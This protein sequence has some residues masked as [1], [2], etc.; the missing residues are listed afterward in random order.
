MLNLKKDP[1]IFSLL[2]SWIVGGYFRS[3][4]TLALAKVNNIDI[5]IHCTL[6]FFYLTMYLL[7]TK[8]PYTHSG[9]HFPRGS[10]V[11]RYLTGNS[12]QVSRCCVKK[13]VRRRK[14]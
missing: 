1:D 3:K 10:A 14:R 13:I 12:T 6:F 8:N 7:F 2:R 4:F 9:C 11:I 5:Q